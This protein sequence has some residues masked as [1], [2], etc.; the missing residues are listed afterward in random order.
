MHSILKRL[1]L[2]RKNSI[3]YFLGLMLFLGKNKYN[4]D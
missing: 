2:G 4:L 3:G 1:D